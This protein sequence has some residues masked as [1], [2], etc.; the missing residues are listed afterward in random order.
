MIQRNFSKAVELFLSCVNTFNANEIMTF[1]Q[2]VYYGCVLG[3]AVLDR[4]E[5]KEK[6]IG[7]SEIL[8]VLREDKEIYNYVFTFYESNYENFFS[9][10]INLTEKFIGKDKFLK[11]H[12]SFLLKKARVAIYK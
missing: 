4:S 6:I 9:S 11:N 2:L 1:D 3:L 12:K 8:A 10:L 7:N 5:V